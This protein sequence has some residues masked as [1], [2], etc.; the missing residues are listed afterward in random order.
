[1][2]TKAIDWERVVRNMFKMIFI[3]TQD[4]LHA[5]PEFLGDLC[6]E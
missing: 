4:I 3:V 2:D 5:K 6:M 1:M